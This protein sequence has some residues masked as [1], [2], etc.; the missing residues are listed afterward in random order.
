MTTP[1]IAVSATAAVAPVLVNSWGRSGGC[2]DTIKAAT[3]RKVAIVLARSTQLGCNLVVFKSLVHAEFGS[4][5]R[6]I[7]TSIINSK[8]PVG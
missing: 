1:K 4:L 8:R 5:R 7:I 3:D 6:L 2:C